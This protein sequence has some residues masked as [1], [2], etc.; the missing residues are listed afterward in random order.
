MIVYEFD[1]KWPP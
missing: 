1:L